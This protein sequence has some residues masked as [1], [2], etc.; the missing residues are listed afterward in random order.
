MAL[1]TEKVN[2]VSLQDWNDLVVA[3][4]GRQY[5]LQQQDGCRDRGSLWITVPN[6][7]TDEECLPTAV[8][9]IVNGPEMGVKFSSWLA[10]DPEKLI[11]ESAFSTTLWWHR[12][13]YPEKNAVANDLYE[14]GLLPA[15][16]YLIDIDW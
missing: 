16:R 10:R 6:D 9:E 4:Y 15:G 12:N 8:P 3:T 5:D 2:Y 14:R 7:D 13:F 1:K 11:E